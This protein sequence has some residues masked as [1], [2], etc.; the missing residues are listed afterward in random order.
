H[1]L[2]FSYLYLVFVLSQL[3][4]WT[5]SDCFTSQSVASLALFLSCSSHS[6]H[7]SRSTEK[8]LTKSTTS[9]TTGFQQSSTHFTD[10]IENLTEIPVSVSPTNGSTPVCLIDPQLA[11][12]VALSSMGLI[13]ILLIS[14]MVLACKVVALKRQCQSR[15]PTRSNVDLVSGTGYW[16]TETIEGGI[17]HAQVPY[18]TSSMPL[19]LSHSVLRGVRHQTNVEGL[20]KTH[21]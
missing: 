3:Q 6:A 21:I 5:G 19:S 14:T 11:F 7:L 8:S 9:F 12:I 17:K 10:D 4:R 2:L 16:G 1:R 15:R 13:I 20:N 18:S